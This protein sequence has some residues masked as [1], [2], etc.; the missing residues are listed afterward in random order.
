MHHHSLALWA[1]FTLAGIFAIIY[2]AA[3]SAGSELTP[4]HTAIGYVRAKPLTTLLRFLVA[5]LIYF[6]LIDNP[7]LVGDLFAGAEFASKVKVAPFVLA[8]A[9]GLASDKLSDIGITAVTWA[10]NRAMGLF[11]SKSDG[12]SA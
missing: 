1:V 7:A 2:K 9:L 8:L 12:A 11:K 3:M 5:Q 10:Y 6:V 4:F